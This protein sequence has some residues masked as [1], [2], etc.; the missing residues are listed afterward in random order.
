VG[1]CERCDSMGVRGKTVDPSTM[2]RAGGCPF[3]YAPF[4]L[5]GKQ[6]KQF[7]VEWREIRRPKRRDT[8]IA[9]RSGGRRAAR[10]RERASSRTGRGNGLEADVHGLC[11]RN[12]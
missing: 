9:E 2:L 11:Y 10:G 12:A 3:D 6:G 4:I 7:K 5:Q 8:E 1:V